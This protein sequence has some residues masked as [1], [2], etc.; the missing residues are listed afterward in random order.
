MA[1]KKRNTKTKRPNTQPDRNITA[2][3]A[4]IDG[5]SQRDEDLSQETHASADSDPSNGDIGPNSD[6]AE[7]L[8]HQENIGHKASKSNSGLAINEKPKDFGSESEYSDR[9]TEKEVEAQLSE[10]QEQSKKANTTL[11]KQYSNNAEADLHTA[12]DNTNAAEQPLLTDTLIHP[13]FRPKSFIADAMTKEPA[14]LPVPDL[15]R[16]KSLPP[17]PPRSVTPEAVPLPPSPPLRARARPASAL[18]TTASPATATTSEKQASPPMKHS[19]FQLPAD[20]SIQS[21]TSTETGANDSTAGINGSDDEKPLINAHA[22]SPRAKD[23]ANDEKA[24]AHNEENE[25][26]ESLA[27]LRARL[28]K[29]IT[30]HETP[31]PGVPGSVTAPGAE[32][33]RLDYDAERIARMENVDLNGNKEGGKEGEAS[34]LGRLG[35]WFG[36]C[37]HL[38]GGE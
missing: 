31:A 28:L 5:K 34:A 38:G 6:K 19:S 2:S 20:P 36:G 11:S 8:S 25:E 7:R 22:A 13:A 32:R 37:M 9:G 16:W 23:D 27:A 10:P 26:E 15:H 24:A 3:K 35:K 33:F 12:E 29:T 14:H 1:K 17:A 4:Q 18:L 21:T 30:F